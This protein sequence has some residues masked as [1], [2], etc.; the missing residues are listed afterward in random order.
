MHWFVVA[1]IAELKKFVLTNYGSY[2]QSACIPH[3]KCHKAPTS[4]FVDAKKSKWE[5]AHMK[6]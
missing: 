3:K 2:A 5:I 4:G 1:H 6:S